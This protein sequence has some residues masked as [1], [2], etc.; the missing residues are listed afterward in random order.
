MNTKNIKSIIIG[1]LFGFILAACTEQTNTVSQ[2]TAPPEKKVLTVG[3]NAQFAPFEVP[4]EENVREII[5]F[6]ID[7]I[8]AMAAANHLDIKI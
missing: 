1:S 7:L 4:S 3:V 6:D 5:G 2:D 8:K